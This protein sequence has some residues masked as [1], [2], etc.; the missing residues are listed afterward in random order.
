MSTENTVLVVDDN[1]DVRAIAAAALARHWPVMTARDVPD[2][3]EKLENDAFVLVVSD[4]EMGG[5][6]GFDLHNGIRARGIQTPF[7]FMTGNMP[8]AQSLASRAGLEDVVIIG[9]P[10]RMGALVEVVR[11]AL[12]S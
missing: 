3:L 10:F 9:K 6:T 4:V 2:A 12:A 5:Q 11:A 1:E 8:E 7:V